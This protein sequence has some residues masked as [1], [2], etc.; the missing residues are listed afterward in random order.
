MIFF[1]FRNELTPEEIYASTAW[2]LPGE[3]WKAIPGFNFYEAS[4]FGRIRSLDHY[5]VRKNNHN[6]TF[7]KGRIMK[8]RMT[9]TGYYSV[10]LINGDDQ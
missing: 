1:W 6:P 7:Y 8:V 9:M 10:C 3:E 4:T 5:T 2:C